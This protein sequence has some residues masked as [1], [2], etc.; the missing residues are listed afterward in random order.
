MLYT[1]AAYLAYLPHKLFS[2]LRGINGPESLVG[3][4]NNFQNKA[5]QHGETCAKFISSVLSYVISAAIWTAA[6]VVTPLT[7]A[8]DKV[9]SK[10]SE[11]KEPENKQK[12]QKV[13]A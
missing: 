13:T 8:V 7:W 1:G 3:Y 12:E 4:A 11:M 5:E 2:Y 6:L 9:S 10:F